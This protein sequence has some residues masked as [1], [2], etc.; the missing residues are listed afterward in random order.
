MIQRIN[1]HE[2]KKLAEEFKKSG[3]SAK[4]YAKQKNISYQKVLYW[5]RKLS[6]NLP[7]KTKGETVKFAA[8]HIPAPSIPKHRDITV[9]IT[10]YEIQIP[11]ELSKEGLGSIFAV[12]DT[13][14]S[15]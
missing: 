13:I 14:C 4:D 6:N 7:D 15:K 1:I 8:V 12:L 10:N 9:K 2:G 11:A 3:M 5:Q